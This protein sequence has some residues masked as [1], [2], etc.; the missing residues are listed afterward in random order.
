MLQVPSS[1]LDAKHVAGTAPSP[2]S[3]SSKGDTSMSRAASIV[4]ALALAA[5]TDNESLD[6]AIRKARILCEN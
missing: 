2:M 3:D 1:I 6:L 4:I 5:A